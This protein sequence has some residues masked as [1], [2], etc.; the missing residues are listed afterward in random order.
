MAKPNNFE[1][2]DQREFLLS[3]VEQGKSLTGALRACNYKA[4]RTAFYKLCGEKGWDD[5]AERLLE[6]EGGRERTPLDGE[7]IAAAEHRLVRIIKD[8]D[9][10]VALRAAMFV[11]T[12]RS[13]RRWPSNVVLT[14]REGKEAGLDGE[15]A[16][17]TL[18]Q[19]AEQLVK[20]DE[21][22]EPD[23]G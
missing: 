19:L 4:G 22:S 11:L 14:L 13:P 18:R 15:V 17:A 1:N 7:L 10:R 5:L 8:G 20:P 16:A 23:G 9:P 6:L 2:P 12:K 3:I 21:E